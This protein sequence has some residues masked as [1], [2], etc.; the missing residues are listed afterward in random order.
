MY[1]RAT[2]LEKKAEEHKLSNYVRPI[3]ISGYFNK[4]SVIKKNIENVGAE[5]KLL[6][7]ELVKLL[8]DGKIDQF[9]PRRLKSIPLCEG[10]YAFLL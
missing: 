6:K 9:W 4:S 5:I 3:S 7:A 8:T 10:F 2:L 1:I